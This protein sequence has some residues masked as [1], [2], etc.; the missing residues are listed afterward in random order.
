[1]LSTMLAFPN[2]SQCVCMC[3]SCGEHAIY[4][5]ESKL[6]RQCR[7]TGGGGGHEP[8]QAGYVGEGM[9]AAAVSGHVFASPSAKAVLA[10]IRAVAGKAGCLLIVTNYTGT[11]PTCSVVH[12][13]EC[14]SCGSRCVVRALSTV[15]TNRNLEQDSYNHVVVRALSAVPAL[16]SKASQLYLSIPACDE[17]TVPLCN[18]SVCYTVMSMTREPCNFMSITWLIYNL[19]SIVT[20]LGAGMLQ[21][22]LLLKGN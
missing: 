9:L 8:G 2:I 1:M 7:I 18:M 3:V 19:F 16:H 15:R 20:S 11:Q 10:A 12:L 17:P 22:T 4:S 6:D 21:Q 5:N 13:C 14:T